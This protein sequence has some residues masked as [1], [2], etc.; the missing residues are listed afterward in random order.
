M[1]KDLARILI[2]NSREHVLKP[3]EVEDVANNLLV[4][5]EHKLIT[6][7]KA[8]K[9]A[10][11]LTINDLYKMVSQLE[12]VNNN[13][14]HLFLA[15]TSIKHKDY[16]SGNGIHY[17]IKTDL[18]KRYFEPILN[19]IEQKLADDPNFINYTQMQE[20]INRGK[21]PD[22]IYYKRVK[23]EK[24]DENKENNVKSVDY[25]EFHW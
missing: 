18:Y 12:H 11:Y 9:T 21:K 6:I 15:I 5:I 10:Y 25:I 3:Y 24:L 19:A 14:N 7:S 23:A 8:N 4:E 16:D 1:Q 17:N 20:Y 22:L 13:C 2:E